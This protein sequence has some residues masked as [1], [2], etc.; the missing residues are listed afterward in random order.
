MK[1]H[2]HGH[3]HGA[4]GDIERLS[5]TFDGPEREKWQ[6]PREVI[7]SFDL[8]DD[9]V[10]AD[11]GAGTGYFAVRLAECVKNG[12]VIALDAE[13]NMTE[14]LKKRAL[15]LRLKN[16]DARPAML[17]DEINLQEK[18]D[19]V[20][21]VDVYHHIADRQGYFSRL[22]GHLKRGGRIAVIDRL[23]TSSVGSHH[24]HHMT[25]QSVKGEMKRAGFLLVRESDLLLPEQFFLLFAPGV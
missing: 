6:K 24:A 1:T 19:L 9:A 25:P 20:L 7:E 4:F 23:A 12:K 17:G 5:Q 2:D 16:V 8:A 18:V 11:V 15:A 10:V 3:A 22:P 14:Y 13:P 21:C